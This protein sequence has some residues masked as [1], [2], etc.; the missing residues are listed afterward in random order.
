[1]S[2]PARARGAILPSMAD[3][4]RFDSRHYP[5]VSV[6]EGYRAWT[7]T[8]EATVEDAMDV[9]LLERIESV[10]WA[11]A[12]RCADLGCGTGR[13]GAWLADRGAS[14][15]DGVDVT[16][17]MLTVARTKGVYERLAEA[18]VAATGF[19]AREYDLVTCCLVD[20]HLA[21]LAP[22]YGEAARLLREEG[23]FVL[24]GYHPFFMMAAGMPTHFEHPER[25]PLA[26]ETHVHFF[27]E[28]IAAGRSAGFGLAEMHERR[29]DDEWVRLKPGW[30]VHRERPISFALVWR[31]DGA[32]A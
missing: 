25:G 15:I 19:A 32:G 26:V 9:A 1:M 28:H 31:A 2:V 13:T 14:G 5:T 20:E 22:L 6:R 21:E 24:V 27:E 4:A 11:T 30:E 17:E 7:P 18:D 12:R 3:F 16:P 29:V 23:W 8:Y 10:P